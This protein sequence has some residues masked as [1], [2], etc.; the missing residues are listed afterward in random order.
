MIPVSSCLETFY[1][2]LIYTL[3]DFRSLSCLR[4]IIIIFAQT[5]FTYVKL[6]RGLCYILY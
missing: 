6:N 2:T 3:Y 1:D 4:Y 5:V